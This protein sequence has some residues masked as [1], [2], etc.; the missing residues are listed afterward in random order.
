VEEPRVHGDADAPRP[1][2]RGPAAGAVSFSRQACLGSCRRE[3]AEGAHPACCIKRDVKESF[4][5]PFDSIQHPALCLKGKENGPA[6][7]FAPRAACRKILDG[8][9][10]LNRIQSFYSLPPFQIITRLNFLILNLTTHFIEK[11]RGKKSFFVVIFLI[12][13]RQ[14]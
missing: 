4:P 8:M 2:G 3:E 11:N 6:C 5:F 12:K 14:E 10:N 7:L 13:V 1:T 9:M